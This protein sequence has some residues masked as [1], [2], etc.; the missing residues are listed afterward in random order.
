MS[1]ISRVLLGTLLIMLALLVSTS[2][3][4]IPPM[5]LSMPAPKTELVCDEQWAE[6]ATWQL[7]WALGWIEDDSDVDLEELPAINSPPLALKESPLVDY[8]LKPE[9][10]LLLPPGLNQISLIDPSGL[11]GR[12]IVDQDF[13]FAFRP[14]PGR[15]RWLPTIRSLG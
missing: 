7:Y 11:F 9:Q 13:V 5:L 6:T 4:I 15:S 8:W 14:S 10:L 3:Q 1:R 2:A 12:L